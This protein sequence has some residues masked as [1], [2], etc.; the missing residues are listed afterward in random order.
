MR[1]TCKIQA[2]NAKA[3]HGELCNFHALQFHYRHQAEQTVSSQEAEQAE[4]TTRRAAEKI[5]LELATAVTPVDASAR[6]MA[7]A[8]TAA[9]IR[10][11]RKVRSP[12]G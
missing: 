4:A 8:G 6:V 2:C 1:R 7:T 10:N 11:G 12:V 9:P 3:W 5:G